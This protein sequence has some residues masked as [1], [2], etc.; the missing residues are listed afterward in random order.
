MFV[1]EFPDHPI[2]KDFEN[3]VTA[4]QQLIPINI[5]GD[6]GRGY[7]K[8]E[9]MIV[10]FQPALGQGTTLRAKVTGKRKD[11]Q[12]PTPE[13]NMRGH[14]LSTRF[15]ISVLCKK[16]YE[17]DVTPLL[18]L[19]GF[20]SDVFGKLYTEGLMA[21]G[22]RYKFLPIGLK[23]DLVFQA[24]VCQLE[25]SFSHIRKRPLKS[26]SK[27]KSLAGVCWRCL[28]GH[29]TVDKKALWPLH[30]SKISREMPAGYPLCLQD[31]HGQRRQPFSGLSCITRT[32]PPS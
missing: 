23:G 28:A 25:R 31:A 20:I 5:H 22:K 15:L 16:F 2:T 27:P 13:V 4:K 26:T 30:P 11:G 24:K 29:E 6:G 12:D 10:Q 1:Q 19:L 8:S 3:G 18:K 9:I 14:S 32:F 17:N 7:R 21:N